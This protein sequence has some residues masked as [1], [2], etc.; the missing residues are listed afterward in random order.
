MRLLELAEHLTGNA[1]R[2]EGVSD[3]DET[4]LDGVESVG[5]TS[6]AS[7]P[8][9]LVQDIL[10]WFRARNPGLDVIE[11]GEWEDIT[12]RRPTPRPPGGRS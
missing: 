8:D 2:I 10:S 9:D 11:E 1:K 4:W 7:T 5:I 3:I 6:A 12:F